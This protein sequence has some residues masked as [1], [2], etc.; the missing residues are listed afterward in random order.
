MQTGVRPQS[1]GAPSQVLQKYLCQNTPKHEFSFTN[2]YLKTNFFFF[3]FFFGPK[4]REEIDRFFD[5][6]LLHVDSQKTS[7]LT[8]LCTTSAAA[9]ADSFRLD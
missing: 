8:S 2:I 5:L 9:A 4:K 3:F 7:R 1:P 6:C